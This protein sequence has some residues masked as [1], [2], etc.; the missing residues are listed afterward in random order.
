MRGSLIILGFFA[1]GILLGVN[2]SLPADL[3]TSNISFY[4][5]CLLMFCVGITVG[6]DTNIL[7]SL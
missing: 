5:L 2:G 7:K 3:L 6:N 4:V 1:L